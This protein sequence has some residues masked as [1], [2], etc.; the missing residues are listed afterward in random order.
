M[1]LN[2]VD[3]KWIGMYRKTYKQTGEERSILHAILSEAVTV[4]CLLIVI[5]ILF[6]MGI[7]VIKSRNLLLERRTR[8]YLRQFQDYFTYIQSH[9]DS[10]ERLKP[11]YWQ[12]NRLE[13]RVLQQKL[14]EWIE[15]LT[16]SHRKKMITLCEDTGLVKQNLQRL[17]SRFHWIRIDAAYHVGTM[18]S[19][20]AV[21]RLLQLLQTKKLDPTHFIIARSIAKCARNLDDIRN[22]LMLLIKHR[23]SNHFLAVDIMKETE[24]DCTPLLLECLRSTDKDLNKIALIGWSAPLTAEIAD[25][26]YRQIDSEDNEVRIQSVRLLFEYDAVLATALFESLMKTNDT[27]VCQNTEIIE[28]YASCRKQINEDEQADKKNRYVYAV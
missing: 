25:L 9:M 15:S 3:L 20:E 12:L 4:I 7:L 18:R 10:P 19:E 2:A 13:M 17:Y 27:E 24:L 8:V 1:A 11:P 23:K 26:V 22:M 21:P 28:M 6:F 16:G 5:I 14:T